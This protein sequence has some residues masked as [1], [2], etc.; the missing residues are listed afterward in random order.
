M[1]GD[2]TG[3]S[4]LLE[5]GEG[6]AGNAACGTDGHVALFPPCDVLKEFWI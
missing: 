4:F 6:L 5:G 3:T 2:G 1:S